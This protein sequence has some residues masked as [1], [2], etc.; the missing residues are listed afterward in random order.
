MPD[1]LVISLMVGYGIF[2]VFAVRAIWR[3]IARWEMSSLGR[4]VWMFLS[5]S[6]L[7]FLL[8]IFVSNSETR[9]LQKASS[10]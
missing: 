4:V 6:P 8:W 5:L 3:D 2:A 1:W 10:R 9:R 7:G